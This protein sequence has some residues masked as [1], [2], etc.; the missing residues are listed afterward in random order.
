V[1][2]RDVTHI[3]EPALAREHKH[4][5]LFALVGRKFLLD[6]NEQPPLSGRVL[7]VDVTIGPLAGMRRA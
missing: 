3:D 6:G 1:T 7:R 4:K 5:L 2:P